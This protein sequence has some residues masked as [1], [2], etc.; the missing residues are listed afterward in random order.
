MHLYIF[1]EPDTR[2]RDLNI[3]FICGS[4][5]FGTA[6]LTKNADPDRYG[7]SVNC[8]EFVTGLQLR[9]KYLHA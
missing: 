2:K 9:K 7:Y 1:Y 5:L 4:C 6:K 3:D 8:I